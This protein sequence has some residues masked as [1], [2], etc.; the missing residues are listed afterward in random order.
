MIIDRLKFK[1]TIEHMID[2]LD[3]LYVN[4][5]LIREGINENAF[6]RNSEYTKMHFL[7]TSLDNYAHIYHNLYRYIKRFETLQ[8]VIPSGKSMIYSDDIYN[9]EEDTKA[10]YAYF[11]KVNELNFENLISSIDFS[12]FRRVLDLH[13]G[14]GILASKIKKKFPLCDIWS[15]ENKNMQK[16]A[17][18]Y[19]NGNQLKDIIHLQFGDL[20]KDQLVEADCIIAPHILMQY[21]REHKEV[22]MRGVYDYLYSNGEFIIMENLIDSRREKDSCGLKISFMLGLLLGYEGSAG[23]F[24]EYRDSLLKC[25]FKSV[26]R[27][28]RGHG[29]SEIIVARK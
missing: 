10:Y 26:E 20:L 22:I 7:Q 16:C 8:S 27:I 23:T 21:S 11:Y 2:L 3:Q 5:F 18:E 13:G 15:Y 1:T 28:T 6:Y 25:G 9:Y 24:E 17:E 14:K 4:G 19:I 12:R 29:M